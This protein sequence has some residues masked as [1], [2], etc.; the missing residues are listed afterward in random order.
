VSRSPSLAEVLDTA[1]SRRLGE[2]HTCLPG[3]VESYDASK[4]T[5]D[6][7]PLVQAFA[8]QEDGTTTTESLPVLSSVPLI[9]PGGGG[10]RATYPVA[11]GDTV[12]VVFA[13]ASLDAWQPRGGVVAPPDTRRHHLADAVAIAGLHDNSKAWTGASTSAATWGKD[14]GPQV[15]AR[16]SALELGGDDSNPPTE[17][18]VLGTTYRSAEDTFLQSLSTGV[19]VG[20]RGGRGGG[21]SALDGGDG[22]RGADGGRRGGGTQLRHRRHAARHR[23]CAARR[24]PGGD[25]HLQ[26]AGLHLPQP[27]GHH[28]MKGCSQ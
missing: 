8:L 2:L 11:S 17:A 12:L 7:Q 15:V 9:F 13:E 23:R 25:H 10:F 28:E 14:G 20:P 1:L 27:K 3:R 24:H 4:Q 16:S 26:G 19:P 6:V 21:N 22:Q 5:V 18:L